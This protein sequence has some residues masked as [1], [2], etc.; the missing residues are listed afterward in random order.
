MCIGNFS[1]DQT[2]KPVHE[3]DNHTGDYETLFKQVPPCSISA[4]SLATVQINC[5]KY[6]ANDPP[7]IDFVNDSGMLV[8]QNFPGG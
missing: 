2:S 8:G 1:A 4:Q 3:H 7:N 6:N 5:I